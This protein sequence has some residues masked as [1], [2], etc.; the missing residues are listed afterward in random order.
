MLTDYDEVKKENILE[1]TTAVR[2][3]FQKEAVLV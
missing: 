3:Y 1:L 2:Q